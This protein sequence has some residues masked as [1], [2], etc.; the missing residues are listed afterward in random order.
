VNARPAS[1]IPVLGIPPTGSGC[2][3]LGR[4]SGLVDR[5]YSRGVSRRFSVT[6]EPP[7]E[8]AVESGIIEIPEEYVELF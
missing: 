8:F 7:W 2:L 3:S 1:G 4:S 5:Q 6:D